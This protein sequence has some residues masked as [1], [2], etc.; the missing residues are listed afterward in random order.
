[1]AIYSTIL[2]IMYCSISGLYIYDGMRT[3]WLM[4]NNT[5]GDFIVGDVEVKV[6]FL[7]RFQADRVSA[8]SL[9]FPFLVHKMYV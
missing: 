5:A 2:N 4:M 8:A 1:M 3:L 7:V 6:R 9:S